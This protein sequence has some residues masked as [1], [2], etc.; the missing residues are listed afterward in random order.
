MFCEP[1]IVLARNTRI[2]APYSIGAL[3]GFS[4]FNVC[5]TGRLLPDRKHVRCTEIQELW[6]DSLQPFLPCSWQ[7]YVLLY[8][9]L[10]RKCGL[11]W[12]K[13]SPQSLSGVKTTYPCSQR[14]WPAWFM[15]L[16]WKISCG[17][18]VNQNLQTWEEWLSKDTSAWRHFL[19]PDYP[20]V[21]GLRISLWRHSAAAPGWQLCAALIWGNDL[22][23]QIPAGPAMCLCIH[24]IKLLEDLS[25]SVWAHYRNWARANS[26]LIQENKF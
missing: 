25:E 14:F 13:N 26:H 17:C 6:F 20:E 1:Y 19:L 11:G 8:S 15:L 3:P 4:Q 24:L 2:T 12:H 18:N 23:N 5:E 10:A 22:L 7:Q 21:W 16:Q 9:Y